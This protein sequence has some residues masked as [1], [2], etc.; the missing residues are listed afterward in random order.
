MTLLVIWTYKLICKIFFSGPKKKDF[1]SSND[2]FKLQVES[3]VLFK[4]LLKQ[5]VLRG[6]WRMVSKK[7]SEKKSAWYYFLTFLDL[8]IFVKKCYKH[9]FQTCYYKYLEQII[10]INIAINIVILSTSER[11][12]LIKV[13]KQWSVSRSLI[14]ILAP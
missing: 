11:F 7:M 13:D 10:I 4:I 5:H 2:M 3:R 9:M 1:Y 6:F 8:R 14:N 12:L